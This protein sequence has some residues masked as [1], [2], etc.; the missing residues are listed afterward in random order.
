MLTVIRKSG[1]Y[2]ID[3]MSK[4]SIAVNQLYLKLPSFKQAFIHKSIASNQNNE[5]LE[6]LGD[7][8]LEALTVADIVAPSL[9]D[10]GVAKVI[11]DLINSA[12]LEL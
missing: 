9:E 3:A 5:R 11:E 8:V 7:A 2:T 6:F 1:F 12:Q 4:N 10:D